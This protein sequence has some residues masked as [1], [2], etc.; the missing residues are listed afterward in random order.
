MGLAISNLT[1]DVW[2]RKR[3]AIFD[4]A[5][6]N[7]YAFG[8]EALTPG[9]VGLSKAE[10]VIVSGKAGYG[11]GYDITRLRLRLIQQGQQSILWHGLF[12][13]VTVTR[14]LL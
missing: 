7:S 11:F 1:Y 2:G 5:F 12:M 13:P 8:G 14:L 6:D 4:M 10:Q 3:A 9:M